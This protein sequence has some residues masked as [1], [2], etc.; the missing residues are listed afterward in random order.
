MGL[1]KSVAVAVA[2]TGEPREAVSQLRAER[3]RF[4]ALAFTSAD[5]LLEIGEGAMIAFA[6]GATK[7]FVGR[8]ADAL[9]GTCFLDCVAKADRAVVERLLRNAR[10]GTRIDNVA[11]RLV[12]ATGE[13]PPL[14]LSGFHMRELGGH[15]YLSLRMAPVPRVIEVDSVG[16]MP[17]STVLDKA[18]FASAATRAVED[19]RASGEDSRL[20]LLDLDNFVEL[21]D[22]LG[23][24]SRQEL[25]QTIGATLRASS[26]RGDTAAQL[27]DEKFSLVHRIDLDVKALVREIETL[28]RA[29]DPAGHGISVA[30]QTIDVDTAQLSEQ[31]AVKALVY[32]INRYCDTTPEAFSFRS[33]TESLSVLAD[34]T[35]EKMGA[36]GKLIEAANFDVAFQ[37]ICDLLTGQP[38]HFEA[39]VRFDKKLGASPYEFV[40]FAEEVGLICDFDLAMCRKVLEWLRGANGAGYKYMVAVNMSGRS[41][42]TPSFV[43]ALLA[44]LRGAG[45]ARDNILFEITESA[46]LDNLPEANNVIQGLRNAGHIVCLDDFGAGVSAFQYLS[47]LHIDVVKIDGGYVHNAIRNVRGKALLKAMAGMCRDLSITT[48]AEMIEREEVARLVRECGIEYGQ[49]YLYGKPSKYI[50]Q[51]AVPKPVSFDAVPMRRPGPAR[52]GTEG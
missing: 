32:T 47:A 8:T 1:N 20:T 49:G 10:R 40:T 37:P 21:R 30:E 15:T 46:K 45:T 36:Y 35:V 44:M 9:V 33:L 38:H 34:E 19:A 16:R 29:A 28:A 6:A 26:L 14:A 13:T 31:D 24:D 11:V 7:A 4:V 50:D 25:A 2:A 3:D 5:I 43:E 22:R 23:E 48:I 27:S 18:S 39:L 51:F 42:S 52:T 12:G 41:L 17:D